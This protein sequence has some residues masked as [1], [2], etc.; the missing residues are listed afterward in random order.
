MESNLRKDM[1]KYYIYKV[2]TKIDEPVGKLPDS[3]QPSQNCGNC[4]YY[5]DL[6]GMCSK[7][8]APVDVTYWCS[9]WT[10]INGEYYE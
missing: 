5:V 1:K 10:K 3:Y 9:S 8:N 4:A 2:K 6:T 7:Y